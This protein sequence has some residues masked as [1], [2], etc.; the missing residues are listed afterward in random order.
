M[1]AY[2]SDEWFMCWYVL[3]FFL[4]AF[5]VLVNGMS[6]HEQKK[7][8]GNY[9]MRADTMLYFVLCLGAMIVSSVKLIVLWWVR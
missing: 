9:G 5:G 8:Y 7:A 2:I 3:G 6:L 1:L 4:G